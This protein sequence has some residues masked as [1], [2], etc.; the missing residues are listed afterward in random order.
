MEDHETKVE[1]TGKTLKQESGQLLLKIIKLREEINSL[2]N[3]IFVTLATTELT[4]KKDEYKH[5]KT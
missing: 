2:R 1:I 4:H 3:D 5:I